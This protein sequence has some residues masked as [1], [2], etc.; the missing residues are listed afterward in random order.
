MSSPRIDQLIEE[1]AKKNTKWMSVEFF[2]PKTDAGIKNLY[3]LTDELHKLN[4]VFA[5]ITWGAGGSTSELTMDIAK[6]LK[7]DHAHVPN[8][9]LTCTNMEKQKVHDALAS[10]K[11]LGITNIVALRGDPPAGQK[12]WAPVEGGFTCALDLVKFIRFEHKDFFCVSVAGYPEGHPNSMTRVED[13]SELT[14][15]ERARCA[16][17]PSEE[18]GAADEIWVCKDAAFEGELD[19]LKQKVDAGANCIITQ[20]FF[21][22]DVFFTFVEKC[23]QK[24]IT[25]PILPG[26]MCVSSK[27]GLGRM[28]KFCKTRIP[29][30]FKVLVD[31]VSEEAQMKPVSVTYTT[32]MC[33]KLLDGGAPGLH[34]Y[35]L[36]QG[37]V[38]TAVCDNLVA[39]GY[40]ITSSTT[41]S[42]VL[43][44][45]EASPADVP[46]TVLEPMVARATAT[47]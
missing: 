38:T 3:H 34:F 36:N 9:H 22:V 17:L 45:A 1:K 44:G 30:D 46:V 25:V 4:P 12:A 8:M 42:T 35:T 6:S 20:L 28:V 23:R 33:K 15:S 37:A 26:I 24:G 29:A 16:T 10:C 39:M 2:P 31:G 47:M 11:E 13:L 40:N 43:T 32:D 27:A 14:D 19:Y 18:A 7:N 5:D 41:E 21:D